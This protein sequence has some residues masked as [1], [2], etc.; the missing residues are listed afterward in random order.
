[1]KRSLLTKLIGG[2]VL[3]LVTILLQAFCFVA[4]ALIER[5]V[6]SNAYALTRMS[7]SIRLIALRASMIGADENAESVRFHVREIQGANAELLALATAY[8]PHSWDIV[9]YPT[10]V[11]DDLSRLPATIRGPL[12]KDLIGFIDAAEASFSG[13]GGRTQLALR[14][15]AFLTFAEN[16]AGQL[17]SAVALIDEAREAIGRFFLAVF[18]LFFAG[19]TLSALAYTLWT[20]VSVR[21]DFNALIAFSRRISEGDFS[22]PPEVERNDE[23]GELAS[24]LKKMSSLETMV[25]ALHA[26]AE[27]LI[28]ESDRITEGFEETV[29]TVRNQVK[30]AED[31]NRGFAGIVQSV[32]TVEE[33]AAS[34]LQTAREGGRAVDKSLQK[35][36]SGMEATRV[37]EERTARIEEIISVIGDVADQTELLSLNAAI[38]AARAGELGRGFTV[39]AQQVRKLADRSARAASEISDLVQSVLDAVRRIAGDYKEIL[40]TGSQLKKELEK[41]SSVITHITDLTHVSVE[42]V[43]QAESSLETMMSLSSDTSRKVDELSMIG[44]SMREVIRELE[45]AI[46]RFT[47]EKR[48]SAEPALS[49]GAMATDRSESAAL[50]LSLGITPVSDPSD[51]ALLEELPA[52]SSTTGKETGAASENVEELESVKD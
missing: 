33:H 17:R 18:C 14:A 47:G 34:S 43:N 13:P 20:L 35:I 41:T 11:R 45:K 36:A 10:S 7:D 51:K 27:R 6:V 22:L 28:A 44:K 39:V 48:G 38:E 26:V 29:T 32:Q 16:T 19:G 25:T 15:P 4:Y 9:V 52:E 46:G 31:T 40:E 37:L 42:G 30:V 50:P 5:D 21:R 23:I 12:Q 8:S 3:L 1:M 24:Q 49:R 2:S